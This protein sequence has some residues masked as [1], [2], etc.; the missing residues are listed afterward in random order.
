MSDAEKLDAV[1][2][3]LALLYK[4][5]APWLQMRLKAHVGPE[6][7]ADLVHETYVR[8]AALPAAAIRKPKG[9]LL[10]VALNLA[11]DDWRRRRLA[12]AAPAPPAS[13]PASQLDQLMLKQ[14][15]L[16]MAPLYRDVFVLARFEGMTYGQIAQLKGVSVHTVRW[17]MARALEHCAAQLRG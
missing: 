10:R 15:I 8:I 3:G 9:F 2:E 5:Y 17:R 1:P 7:A 16:S 6:E 14:I 4:R 13:D 11:R 12:P